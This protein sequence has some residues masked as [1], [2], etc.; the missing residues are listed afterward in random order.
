MQTKL[1][2]TAKHKVKLSV[3]VPPE[4][5]A[6]DLD[7]TYRKIANQVK[8]P[9]FRKGKAPRRI[10]DA[11]VGREAVIE[12]FVHDSVYSY[13]MKAV[14]EHDL[15]PIADPEI[16]VEEVED[17]KPLSFTAEVEVR[18]R[19]KLE[20][21]RGVE[22]DRPSIEVSDAEIEGFVDRLRERF[23]ELEPVGHPARK[24]DFVLA[25]IRAYVHETEIPE[26]T[27]IDFLYEVGSGQLVAKLDEELDGK[28]SGDILK[29]N[30]ELPADLGEHGGKEVAFQVLVKE[31]KSRKLPA[32]DDDFAKTASEFDTMSELRED[33]RKKLTAIK[34]GEADAAVRDR[35][36]QVLVDRLDVELPE[37]L[38]DAET[39][40]RVK[41]ARERAER[42][43]ITLEEALTAQGWDELRFRSDARTHAV[44]AIEADLILEAVARQEDLKVAPE[45]LG[46]EIS[47]LAQML[48][49]DAKEV[50]RSLDRSGQ[51]VSVAGDILRAKALD[52]L[53]EHADV[54]PRGE[55][56]P[57]VGEGA[58]PSAEDQEEK[59]D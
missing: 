38:V 55:T 59:D 11:Q 16:S 57:E 29:F 50:A 56:P 2:E 18:P 37:S 30:A 17:G 28:G 13:Y 43:G 52:F 19:L 14:R 3:E 31:V 40:D 9:G 22:V 58:E 35:V 1:E 42:S 7:R 15:A 51:I 21:Y 24:G 12:E 39:E 45:E 32:A 10:I 27:R 23:S 20:D 4:E 48:G 5:F 49:R 25:D 41:T 26:V 6:G 8:V 47:G 54:G 36:L 34:E 33:L 53:V 46:A 44:R